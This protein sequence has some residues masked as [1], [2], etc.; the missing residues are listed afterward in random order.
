MQDVCDNMCCAATGARKIGVALKYDATSKYDAQLKRNRRKAAGCIASGGNHCSRKKFG[1]AGLSCDEYPFASTSPQNGVRTRIS[2]CVKAKS[3]IAQGGQISAFL[4]S[5]ALNTDFT[6]AFDSGYTCDPIKAC[7]AAGTDYQGPGG[8]AL[9]TDVACDGTD[10]ENEDDGDS[11]NSASC[12]NAKRK[13]KWENNIV[14][15]RYLLNN[16]DVINV[17][18]GASPGQQVSSVVAR[19]ETLW[20]EQTLGFGSPR[21]SRSLGE[22]KNEETDDYDWMVFNLKLVRSNIVAE[23]P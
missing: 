10:G 4:K 11:Q 22:D 15:K 3:N 16:G 23:L 17:P 13:I 1:I 14:S 20:E 6:I 7:T 8:T 2:R 9:P 18:G 21:I 12:S 19:N 5:S